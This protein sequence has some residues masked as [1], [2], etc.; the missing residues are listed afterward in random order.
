MKNI[1]YILLVFLLLSCGMGNK[2]EVAEQIPVKELTK[3][4]KLFLLSPDSVLEYYDLSNDS[5]SD[6]P[7]LSAYTIKSLDLSYNLLDTIHP[8]FLPQGLEK[9]NLS[10]NLYSG[11]LR[12]RKNTIPAL[13]E[14]DLSCNSLHK[15]NICEPL[16]RI[17]LSH[18]DLV[19]A[20]FNHKNLQYL[21][22]SYN[23]RMPEKVA[24][25]PMWIDTLVREGVADG[26]ELSGAIRNFFDYLHN[27]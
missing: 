21:D 10:H 8:D 17:L 13:R 3:L 16:F 18:N 22:I 2:K 20:N 1:S 19:Y 27:K 7:D 11:F 26:K 5:I 24:F 12:M 4:E 6:F 15:I 25:E 23:S 9:L 14:L